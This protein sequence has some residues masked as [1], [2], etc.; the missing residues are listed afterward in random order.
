M[1]GLAASQTIIAAITLAFWFYLVGAQL[2]GLSCLL[3]AAASYGFL[4]WNW[5][6]AKIFMGDVG[7]IVIGAWFAILAVIGVNYYDMPILSFIMLLAVF[8]GDA[9]VT[10]LR[11]MIGREAFW[12]PHRTHHYQR[13]ATVGYSHEKIV[14]SMLCFMLLC[15]ILASISLQYRD[16][17][18]LCLVIVVILLCG[19][20]MLVNR[21]ERAV[22][23]NA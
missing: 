13:L 19:A 15:S 22:R 7:S 3:L 8:I 11:R 10:L 12:L 16:I 17:I 1:D 20:A 21:F 2:L 4:L 9:S 18:W 23:E 6:P 14:F 5:S